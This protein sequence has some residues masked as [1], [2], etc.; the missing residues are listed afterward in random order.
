[1]QN[2]RLKIGAPQLPRLY[3]VLDEEA[4]DGAG[5]TLPDLARGCLAGGA[6]FLQIRAKRLSSRDYL[7]ACDEVMSMAA[8]HDAI[9]VVND[10]A[11]IARLCGAAG[12]HVGQE[13]LPP[14]AART[15]IGASAIVGLSTHTLEQ[16]RE[17]LLQPVDYIAVGPVFG[18]STK[19]TGYAA[20][21]LDLVARAASLA[22]AAGHDV[23][24]P[25][26][27]IVAIGGIILA[28]ARS[29]IEAGAASVAVISDLMTT[30]DPEARVREFLDILG[31]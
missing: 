7:A 20:V 22:R 17:G 9:V 16:V 12:V 6:R 10:R 27:P 25:V 1:M 19:E 23:D 18:T 3:V 8:A 4:A 11:D 5:W 13:D 28:R 2:V 26:P 30:G 15:A 24:S 29:V 14:S 31:E 21:G